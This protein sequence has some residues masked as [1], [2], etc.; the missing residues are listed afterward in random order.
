MTLPK[1]CSIANVDRQHPGSYN[2]KKQAKFGR[3][4]KEINL[5]GKREHQ[6]VS[7]V[8]ELYEQLEAHVS[9]IN[10]N[11]N[12]FYENLLDCSLDHKNKFDMESCK[13]CS[14]S[15]TAGISIQKRFEDLQ[16]ELV[17]R[18][19]IAVHRIQT[20]DSDD[21]ED[22]CIPGGDNIHFKE[23]TKGTENMGRIV[24]QSPN[25]QGGKESNAQST[26]R[27]ANDNVSPRPS[28]KGKRKI[29]S[30]ENFSAD[31]TNT[32]RQWFADHFDDP[33]PTAAEK[34]EL[35]Q[36]TGLTYE[37]IQHWFINT[38]MRVWRPSLKKAGGKGEFAIA[39]FSNFKPQ[40]NTKARQTAMSLMKYNTPVT[41]LVQKNALS[42]EIPIAV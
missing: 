19:V 11:L 29:A 5:I 7:Q 23:N 10:N 18:Y 21:N 6:V 4:L 30:R 24:N 16:R 40:T 17:E 32:L 12:R 9:Y 13:S 41:D 33:Y 3:V 37:Q 34:T 28:K 14:Q 8:P 2:L 38:R 15:L 25:N 22:T 39:K 42:T 20:P 36:K 26:K 1:T 35:S 31:A 27:K